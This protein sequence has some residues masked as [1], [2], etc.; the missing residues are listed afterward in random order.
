MQACAMH[1]RIDMVFGQ[2]HTEAHPHTHWA[3]LTWLISDQLTKIQAASSA[4]TA[5]KIFWKVLW[6]LRL[7]R[8]GVSSTLS[9]APFWCTFLTRGANVI[10]S[11]LSQVLRGVGTWCWVR[12]ITI[13]MRG[14]FWGMAFIPSASDL[15]LIEIDEC[16]KN[17]LIQSFF[18]YL[19]TAI[20][21]RRHIL[22][23]IWLILLLPTVRR[24]TIMSKK[25]CFLNATKVRKRLG[26]ST[27]TPQRVRRLVDRSQHN[28]SCPVKDHSWIPSA[29]TRITKFCRDVNGDTK[30]TAQLANINDRKHIISSAAV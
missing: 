15:S 24:K 6:I 21:I 19:N 13:H 17:D 18:F 4:V 30:D 9:F 1:I 7:P 28:S 5:Q 22:R 3:V 14:N 2:I 10:T 11:C 29:N 27:S 26:R 16:N 20:C 8:I 12:L 25:D 23:N